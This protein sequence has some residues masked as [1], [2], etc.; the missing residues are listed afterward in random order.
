MASLSD[1]SASELELL[2]SLPYKVGVF[3][4]HADDED[5]ELD[6]DKEMGA[7][8]ACIKAIA[9]LHADKPLTADIMRQSL[10]MRMDWPRWAAQ[11]FHV[12][13][14]ARRAMALMQA[15]ASETEQ[16]NYASALIEI[17]TTVAQAYG[18]FGEFDDDDTSGSVFGGLVSKIS[19][20]L[21]SLTSDDAA[22]PMNV[23]AAEDTA[24]EALR[25]ALKL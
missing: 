6:D 9:A 22:H 18:E 21:S 11:S 10:S 3:V 23:S 25:G 19:G 24:L 20:A 13:D 12:P 1:F 4:S 2:V 7:L 8:E 16:K 14:E 5:G 15:K 17:A